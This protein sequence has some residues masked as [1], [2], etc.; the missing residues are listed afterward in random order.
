ML[1]TIVLESSNSPQFATIGIMATPFILYYGAKISKR[2][3]N[4][5][6]RKKY[7]AQNNELRK[8]D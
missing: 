1:D 3:K 8:N 7:Q 5:L 4:Y 6:D 2:Y